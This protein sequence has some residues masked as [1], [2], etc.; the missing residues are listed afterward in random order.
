[1]E[2][3]STVMQGVGCYLLSY[4]VKRYWKNCLQATPQTTGLTA[5]K[6]TNGKIASLKSIRSRNIAINFNKNIGKY[7][8]IHY[9]YM[10]QYSQFHRNKFSSSMIQNVCY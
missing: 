3:V 8:Y 5:P 6:Y 1:M 9:M 7:M 10:Y 2:K 4:I